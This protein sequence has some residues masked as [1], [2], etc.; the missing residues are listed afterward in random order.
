M[1]IKYKNPII[2]GMRPDPSVVRV[3]NRY[4]LANS[5][6]EYYPGITIST[7]DDLLNWKTLGG[8]AVEPEQ[9]DLRKSKSNEGIFAANIRFHDEYFY[10]ITTNFAEFKTFIIRGKLE[11]GDI[12]W[13]KSRIEVEVPGI[14]PD[15]FFED[16][17]TYVQFT[18]YIDDKGTKAIRQVEI[19]L[20]TGKIL[21]GPKILTYGTGGRDVEGP[22][23]FKKD[24][25]YYLLVAEGGTG[26][27]HMITIFRSNDLWGPYE[28]DEQNPIFTN[29]DRAN[30]VVQNVGHGDLF[31]DEK[32]N[33][34]LVCLGTRPASVGFKQITNL[35]RETLLYPVKWKD[36]W[37]IV[38]NGVPSE[39]VDLND[40]PEH[41]AALKNEQNFVEF[42]DNFE[43]A[44]LDPEWL[45]LRDSLKDHLLI[46][47]GKLTLR[48]NEY[49][50]SDLKTPAFVGLRQSETHEKLIVEI[51]QTDSELNH[52]EFGLAS[53]IDADNHI[54]IMVKQNNDHFEIYRDQQIFD[55]RINEKIGESSSFPAKFELLNT[56]EIKRFSVT[57]SKG[58]EVIFTT[59]AIHLSNEAIA[60]LNTGDI[61]GMYVKNNANMVID[62]V[63]KKVKLDA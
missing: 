38:N 4:Y 27:G 20:E 6:F 33:W 32:E 10:V 5:T 56:K 50:L 52:G 15:L 47:N 29:R 22:H 30:E 11:N 48:G 21:D 39:F 44:E 35:G 7:S 54:A 42:Q 3:N 14:D 45:T 46:K 26:S 23:I 61:E 57:D 34:W 13:E 62:K 12:S 40:F 37:P 63:T 24:G 36:G 60:A 17:K 19:D 16:G 59:D 1:V 31:T 8:V 25:L 55:V 9:A 43:E 28:S 51:D 18:G 49:S 2:R 41:A 53:V 58:Q